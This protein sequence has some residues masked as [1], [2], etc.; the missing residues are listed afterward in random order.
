MMQSRK[1]KAVILAV[2]LFGLL[3]VAHFVLVLA[4]KEPASALV[5]A[6]QWAVGAMGGVIAIFVGATA[7]EDGQAK[8]TGRTISAGGDVSVRVD[9][10]RPPPIPSP[11]TPGGTS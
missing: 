9:T 5:E 8:S 11:L 4:G 7:Y 6:S 1:F 3:L 10:V 2:V